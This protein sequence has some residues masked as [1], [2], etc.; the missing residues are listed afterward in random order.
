MRLALE[1]VSTRKTASE[2]A[3]FD[4]VTGKCVGTVNIERAYPHGQQRY[5]TRVIRLFDSKSINNF[6]THVECVAF[7]KGV[8]A[9]LNYMLEAKDVKGVKSVLKNILE[10]KE[11]ELPAKPA[12]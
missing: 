9:L 3:I 8:E 12:D 2:Y 4:E 11:F 7:V 10:A 5:P 6:N 1:R